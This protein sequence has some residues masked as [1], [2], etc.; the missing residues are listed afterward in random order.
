MKWL[1]ETDLCR[2]SFATLDDAAA[3]GRLEAVVW[4]SEHGGRAT[5]AA[6]DRA[7]EAGNADVVSYL[8]KNRQEVSS[9]PRCPESSL[10]LIVRYNGRVRRFSK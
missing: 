2:A 6:V 10:C 3:L 7:A 4:L 9:S 5:E 8:L 1:H